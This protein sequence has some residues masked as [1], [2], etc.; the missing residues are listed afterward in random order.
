L[1]QPTQLPPPSQKPPVHVTD[2]PLSI[3]E[4]ALLTQVNVLHSVFIPEHS[5]SIVPHCLQAP[6]PSQKPVLHVVSAAVLP[7]MH[8]M[9]T[10]ATVWHSG[11]IGQLFVIPVFLQPMH[12]PPEQWSWPPVQFGSM[13]TLLVPHLWLTHVLTWQ[14]G[15][16]VQSV[17]A[18]HS[19]QVAPLQTPFGQAE[20]WAFV[21]SLHLCASQLAV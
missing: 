17:G 16:G 20:P 15:A 9:F 1:L 5:L 11:G 8:C 6:L 13:L 18:L 21:V 10:Q 19:T 7:G 4:Q 3:S 14:A 2:I 12:M